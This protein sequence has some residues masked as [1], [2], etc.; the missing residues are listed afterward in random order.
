M[1]REILCGGVRD[2]PS[3]AWG[4]RRTKDIALVESIGG[5]DCRLLARLGPQCEGPGHGALVILR[6]GCEGSAIVNNDGSHVRGDAAMPADA[7][8][9]SQPA[10]RRCKWDTTRHGPCRAF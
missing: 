5:N 1:D 9:C 8:R 7:K 2:E 10:V 4:V 3:E 6:F